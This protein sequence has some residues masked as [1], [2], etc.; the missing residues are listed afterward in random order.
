MKLPVLVDL[1]VSIGHDSCRPPQPRFWLEIIAWQQ[2]AAENMKFRGSAG[3]RIKK[4]PPRHITLCSSYLLLGPQVGHEP[5]DPQVE[6]FLDNSLVSYPFPITN[7]TVRMSFCRV[8]EDQSCF[9]GNS[10]M[11]TTPQHMP[12]GFPSG[13]IYGTGI[14]SLTLYI[15]WSLSK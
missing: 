3:Q 10:C 7:V 1:C 12:P 2:H 13:K 11:A 8:V 5:G 9:F 6:P 4:L 15:G 14:M